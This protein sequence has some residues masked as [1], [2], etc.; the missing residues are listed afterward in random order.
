MYRVKSAKVTDKRIK[1]MNE[2]ISGMRL[3]KMYAWEWAFHKHVKNIRK[4][5]TGQY[6]A[7]CVINFYCREESKI[8][9]QGSLVYAYNYSVSFITLGILSFVVFS[10]HV[11][12]GNVLTPKKVFST[13]ILL[14]F[15]RLFFLQLVLYCLLHISEMSVAVKRIQVSNYI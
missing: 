12:L 1:V 9:T 2:I 7:L 6:T 13:L 10:T 8:I 4:L 15:V 11:G 14:F 3:I 5:D